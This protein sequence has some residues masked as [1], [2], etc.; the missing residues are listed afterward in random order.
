M[1][2][3]ALFLPFCNYLGWNA[4]YTREVIITEPWEG[5][6]PAFQIAAKGALNSYALLLVYYIQNG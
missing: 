5:H 4:G 1:I 3:A 2:P 6:R